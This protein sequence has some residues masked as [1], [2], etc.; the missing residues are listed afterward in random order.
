MSWYGWSEPEPSYLWE[1][2]SLS[3]S[4]HLGSINHSFLNMNQWRSGNWGKV[5]TTKGF[6]TY[7]FSKFNMKS[8]QDV[9]A[10]PRLF[11]MYNIIGALDL[12]TQ[13]VHFVLGVTYTRQHKKEQTKAHWL[14]SKSIVH[15]EFQW[16]YNICGSFCFYGDSMV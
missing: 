8:F 14:S 6:W 5:T 15:Y 3:S 2:E 13:H 1:Q 4:G 7:D 9:F 11:V 16:F 12:S 10:R